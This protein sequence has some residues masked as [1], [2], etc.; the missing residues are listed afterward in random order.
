MPSTE[1]PFFKCD[2]SAESRTFCLGWHVFSL[3]TCVLDL[4]NALDVSDMR[5]A[6]SPNFSDSLRQWSSR[7]ALV[8]V[9]EA[10]GW[11][12]NLDTM[13]YGGHKSHL[14]VETNCFVIVLFATGLWIAISQGLKLAALALTPLFSPPTSA[15]ALREQMG[16]RFQ[17]LP[18]GM[19][20]ESTDFQVA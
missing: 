9:D 4:G 7:I 10:S 14:Q 8:A 1:M 5:L 3:Y 12:R 15:Q 6:T 13:D 20:L 19:D 11:P 2:V 18:P 17:A 16:P